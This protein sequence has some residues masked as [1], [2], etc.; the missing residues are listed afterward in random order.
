ML[1]IFSSYHQDDL[2]HHAD[3]NM[4]SIEWNTLS[5]KLF[6]LLKKNISLYHPFRL[7]KIN[8]LPGERLK[9]THLY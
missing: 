3:D 8:M 4:I 5:L 7:V 1:F 9:Q 2:Y 6:V